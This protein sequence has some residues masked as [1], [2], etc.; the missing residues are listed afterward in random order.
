MSHP[1]SSNKPKAS[2]AVTPSLKRNGTYMNYVLTDYDKKLHN[3]FMTN[4]LLY[5]EKF[6]QPVENDGL[7]NCLTYS[8]FD[9]D[10]I[11]MFPSYLC[12]NNAKKCVEFK[13]ILLEFLTSNIQQN[14]ELGTFLSVYIHEAQGYNGDEYN[15]FLQ[16]FGRNYQYAGNELTI[17]VALFFRVNV[18]QVALNEKG[19]QVLSSSFDD[20][21]NI[22]DIFPQ[23]KHLKGHKNFTNHSNVKN[24]YV[25]YH[26]Y[27]GSLIHDSRVEKNHYIFLKMVHHL[28]IP[29]LH[30]NLPIIPSS[31]KKTSLST[32]FTSH[33]VTPHKI[34]DVNS[35]TTNF[36]Q[37][38]KLEN[39]IIKNNNSISNS[40]SN[41]ND[42]DFMNRGITYQ[43]IKYQPID[44]SADGNCLF[45]SC[46]QS[47]LFHDFPASSC[48]DNKDE[49]QRFRNSLGEF[50]LQNINDTSSPYYLIL[51]VYFRNINLEIDMDDV[52]R[53][54]SDIKKNCSYQGQH[55][56][57]LIFVKYKINIQ[58]LSLC[59]EGM[60]VQKSGYNMFHTRHNKII[61]IKNTVLRNSEEIVPPLYDLAQQYNET[62]PFLCPNIHVFYHRCGRPSYAPTFD[63][64]ARDINYK[65]HFLY[66]HPNELLI[67][68]IFIPVPS[69][70]REATETEIDVDA[71]EAQNLSTDKV[72]E[73]LH[74]NPRE[75]K[76]ELSPIDNSLKS[77]GIHGSSSSPIHKNIPSPVDNNNIMKYVEIFMNNPKK[78]RNQKAFIEDTSNPLVYVNDQR[79]FSKTVSQYRKANKK[80]NDMKAVV[81]DPNNHNTST[82]LSTPKRKSN[83]VKTVTPSN[84]RKKLRSNSSNSS[85]SSSTPT[86]IRLNALKKTQSKGIYC[87]KRYDITPKKLSVKFE[88]FAQA[89]TCKASKGC[90]EVDAKRICFCDDFPKP[91]SCTECKK[92]TPCDLHVMIKCSSSTCNKIFHKGC[93]ESIHKDPYTF[94]CPS[95]DTAKNFEENVPWDKCSPRNQAIRIGCKPEAIRKIPKD[96]ISSLPKADQRKAKAVTKRVI[97]KQL[98]LLDEANLP[99][100]V[101]EKLKE[102][103]PLQFPTL[104][105]M[106][107]EMLSNH[108]IH[109]RIYET[110]M[111]CFDVKQCTCCG[112]TQPTHID[113]DFPKDQDIPFQHKH[114]TRKYHEAWEC[115]CKKVCNGRQF[116]AKARPSHINFFKLHHQAKTPAE[117]LKLD[118]PNAILCDKCY[119]EF[120]NKEEVQS[121]LFSI[122]NYAL[123]YL[124]SYSNFVLIFIKL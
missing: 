2:A 50:V 123:Y 32:F 90:S 29:F 59:H 64:D 7:G 34:D 81:T 122:S 121:K 62:I 108:L 6:F 87:N 88:D 109:G 124:Y 48:V 76:I 55:V 101:V 112:K 83:D 99:S 106:S 100:H 14:S 28:P 111:L 25:Y 52:Y 67:N 93:I 69:H 46:F 57:F 75:I 85:N 77:N 54:V 8:I 22:I 21:A 24:V 40:H 104:T 27:K 56:L 116:Y 41:F 113:R 68:P 117:Y 9:S 71:I 118:N 72:V 66:L 11:T 49:C 51:Q 38:S 44:N 20:I 53:I 3:A 10:T 17:L 30:N 61:K 37:P 47:N 16:N 102:T 97:Q 36:K 103:E 70:R 120:K 18:I 119:W 63:D 26:H 13:N 33:I 78:W 1:I 74:S 110:S 107:E 96:D 58:W 35:N 73:S 5:N 79:K 65:N 60:Y 98:D 80:R 43:D 94:L 45:Y 89:S 82:T 95:C 115:N 105:C 42:N 4:G 19:L 91:E 15:M 114:L 92:S 39:S 86:S 23:L 84:H 31:D 12:S